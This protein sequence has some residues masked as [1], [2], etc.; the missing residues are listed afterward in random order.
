MCARYRSLCESDTM[1]VN[2]QCTVRITLKNC[3]AVVTYS[4]ETRLVPLPLAVFSADK[5]GY[6]RR[7]GA[8]STHRALS[9]SKRQRTFEQFKES[10]ARAGAFRPILARTRGCRAP[11]PRRPG[12][13][14]LTMKR[15][16]GESSPHNRRKPLEARPVGKQVR[17]GFYAM[18]H[19]D[20]SSQMTEIAH[21]CMSGKLHLQ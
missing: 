10:L 21:R 12:C 17:H 9:E 14:L 2:M 13:P 15:G 4:G 19:A 7:T 11:N 18:L 3:C 16:V 6:N 1:Y 5:R 8:F 20:V